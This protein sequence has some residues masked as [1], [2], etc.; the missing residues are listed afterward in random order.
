MRCVRR[1]SRQ[2]LPVNWHLPS[3]AGFRALYETPMLVHP[4]SELYPF[5]FLFLPILFEPWSISGKY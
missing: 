3:H 1:L 5:I 2:V 4:L